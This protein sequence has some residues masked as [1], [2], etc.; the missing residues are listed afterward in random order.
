M[1]RKETFCILPF[2]GMNVHI[3][4]GLT[5][6]CYQD[7]GKQVTHRFEDYDQW[8][9]HGLRDLK[10]DLLTGVKNPQCQRCWD[11]ESAGSISY[12][13]QYNKHYGDHPS[14]NINVD[15]PGWEDLVYDFRMLHLEFDSLCN[16]RCIMC[17]PTVS[18]SLETE[19]K[20]NAEQYQPFTGVI[21]FEKV[22]W[23]ETQQFESLLSALSNVDTLMVTGGE[24]LTNPTFIRLLKSFPN[25]EELNISVTTNAT[26]VRDEVYDLLARAKTSSITVSLE[27]IGAHNDYLR[28]GSD[29]ATVDANIQRLSQLPNYRWVKI[30][31]AT[32]LQY[33]SWQ[34]LPPLIDY[35]VERGYDLRINPLHFPR[36]LTV[37]AMTDAERQR[38]IADLRK[39]FKGLVISRREPRGKQI[40]YAIETLLKSQ[41]DSQSRDKFFSYVEMLDSIR[42]TR[43]HDVFDLDTKR[44]KCRKSASPKS[45]S[46]STSKDPT[47]ESTSG[48]IQSDSESTECGGQ[49]TQW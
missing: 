38:L 1:D 18:T 3:N 40:T 33:T 29:W 32:V 6:C 20:L 5:P 26:V 45:P 9:T 34:S 21:N 12:R 25:L 43:F 28:H 31:I 2:V 14:W 24:P 44:K 47:P 4:G 15:E 10:R 27:G 8:R 42:G 36:Y 13:K 41:P 16:L 48:Q 30:G 46:S 39:K 22:K 17:H 37:D 35:C 11:E 7:R 19:Y 23:T 49:N